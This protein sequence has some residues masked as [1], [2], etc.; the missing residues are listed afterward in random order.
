MKTSKGVIQGYVG[1]T[2][3]DSENQVIVA[4]EAFGQGQEHDLLE[5]MVNEVR[6]NFKNIG[7]EENVLDHAKL[8]ADAGFHSEANMKMLAENEID[9]YVAD[10]QFR[11]RDP[12]FADY[13]RY[14]ER[15]RKERAIQEVRMNLFTPADFSFPEDLSHCICPAGKRLY[16]SGANIVQK[17]LCSTRFK[18]PQSAC[19]P[20]QLRS[21]CL[22][23]PDRTEFRQVAYFHGQTEAKKN[24]FTEKMKRKIDSVA[25]KAIYSMRLAVGEPPFAHIRSVMKLDRFTLRGKNKVDVQWKLFCIVHNLK[26]VHRYGEG[27]V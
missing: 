4:T 5:P 1:V 15:S 23:H 26:K 18:G 14:K 10:N 12:R 19:V 24:S 9:G 22:R 6:S 21:K 7:K 20:C 27:F 3:V 2:A 11:K 13:D 25:G 17:G 8:T 16:R